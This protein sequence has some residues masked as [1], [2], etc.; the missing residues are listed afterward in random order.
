MEEKK[1]R[2]NTLDAEELNTL[3]DDVDYFEKEDE[4]VDL[5]IDSLPMFNEFPRGMLMVR[6]R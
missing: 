6:L 4:M 5:K 1:D 3:Q 2:E